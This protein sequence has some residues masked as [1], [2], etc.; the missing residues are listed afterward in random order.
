MTS[1]RSRAVAAS[2][3]AATIHAAFICGSPAILLSPLTT[4]TGTPSRPAAKLF[5]AAIEAVIEKDLVH[6]QR[7]IE[8]AAE[9]RQLLSL[10]RLG[11]VAGGVVGMHQ[12]DGPRLRRDGAA[13][14]LRIDLPAVVVDERRGF[15]LT[16]SSTARKSKSG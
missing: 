9:A 12:D 7:Q 5:P 15:Q 6:N 1:R 11:E 4:K 8:L 14:P 13:K 10:P 2:G 16:S 3:P